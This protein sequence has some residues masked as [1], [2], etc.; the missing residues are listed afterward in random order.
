VPA[1]DDDAVG[2]DA[3]EAAVMGTITTPVT[4]PFTAFFWFFP[5]LEPGAR[6]RAPIKR[7]RDPSAHPERTTLLVDTRTTKASG[8]GLHLA[9]GAPPARRDPPSPGACAHP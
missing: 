2:A 8:V 6:Q 7:P 3:P 9:R 5:A 4:F 1:G